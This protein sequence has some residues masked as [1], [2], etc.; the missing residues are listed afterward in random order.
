[1]EVRVPKQKPDRHWGFAELARR[2]GDFALAGLAAIVEQ[3]GGRINDSRLVY[4]GC[5]DHARPARGVALKLRG[6]KVPLGACEWL[7]DA[8]ASDLNP[9]DSPGLKA[10][11]KIQLATALTR[12]TL[13]DLRA[14]PAP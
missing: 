8:I 3:D 6:E 10:R 5:T 11:T 4:F 14:G 2:H 7:P 1:V 9:L 12:R 13:D